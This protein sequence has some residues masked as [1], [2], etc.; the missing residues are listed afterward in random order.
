MQEYPRTWLADGGS[1]PN[2]GGGTKTDKGL[3]TGPSVPDPT[4]YGEGGSDPNQGGGTKTDK[5]L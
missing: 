3:P 4:V 1:D 5:G 2:Q